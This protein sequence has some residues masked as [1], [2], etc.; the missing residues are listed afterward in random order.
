[1]KRESLVALSIFLSHSSKYRDL[2]VKVKLSLQALEADRT[3]DIRFSDDMAGAVNWRQWIEENVL[4]SDVFLLL[5]PSATM[6]MGW[7]N[8]ELGRFHD[9]RRPIVCI[10]N[11]DI[12]SPP[13]AFQ[14][15]QS[16]DATPA[17]LYKFLKELFA[18]GEFSRKEPLNADVG[19]PGTEFYARAMEVSKVIAAQFAEARVR[20]HFFERRIVFT[21]RYSG[22]GQLDLDASSVNGN[23][24]GLHV[25]GLAEGSTTRWSALKRALSQN[26]DWLDQ[27]EA[28]LPDVA[29]GA[30]PPALAPYRSLSSPGIYLPIVIKAESA[31][32]LPRQ[33][34]VIFVSAGMERLGWTFPSAMPEPLKYLMQ[35]VR[36]MFK[37]RWDI[38]EPRFQ[39]A[40]F[41]A[42]TAEHC[43]ELAQSVVR[44]YESM[45]LVMQ[46]EQID[47]VGKFYGAFDR[48]LRPEVSTCS[49]EFMALDRR[50]RESSG[51][52]PEAVAATLEELLRNNLRWLS[53]ASKQLA[54]NV[55][56]LH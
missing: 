4:S 8:Y 22:S 21:L 24:E 43:T 51:S 47:G 44:D 54:R 36:L 52:Q 10:K 17:K 37:A 23:A 33:V 31:D 12:A 49:D 46:Q 30:L 25:L 48:D 29:A 45:Q 50:L 32:G 16:Y 56:D 26:A 14:P 18:D 34:I 3:L 39:E 9:S 38:L 53:L 20:E 1:V 19:R 15:Y 27:L 13:P 11:T 35:L 40:R 55:E 2:A 5:Y 41:R 7:C 28:A 42:R 6:E